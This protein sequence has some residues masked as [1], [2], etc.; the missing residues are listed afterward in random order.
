MTF[1]LTIAEKFAIS[2]YFIRKVLVNNEIGSWPVSCVLP[3][4]PL[5]QEKL[6]FGLRNGAQNFGTCSS[7]SNNEFRFLSSPPFL[8]RSLSIAR[9]PCAPAPVLLSE[10]AG[11]RVG[12]ANY[13]Y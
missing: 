13:N 2:S 4:Q 9:D 12:L 8:E 11:V 10:T 5:E 6:Q 7:G 1:S 3:Q